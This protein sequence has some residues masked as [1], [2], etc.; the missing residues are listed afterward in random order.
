MRYTWLLFDADG[1]LFDYDRAEATALLRTF[2]ELGCSYEARYAEVYRQI[3]GEI[4][5]EF[6]QG[7]ISQ[8]RLRTR[9]FEL[10]FEDIGVHCDAKVFSTRYL[11][12]LAEGTDLIEGAE[13]V[14]RRLHGK[15][16]LVLITNGIADVQRPRF[17]SSGLRDYFADI[18]I[19]EEVGASKPDPRIFDSAFQAMGWPKKEEVLIVGDS[20]TSDVKGGNNYGI[21]ACWFNPR[22]DP[23]A[24]DVKIRFEIRELRELLTLFEEI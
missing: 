19:S 8:H 22:Q 12:H 16:G 6:E 1:T 7:K 23:C 17:A 15:A 21:D 13:E 5:R 18:V 14:V 11:L 24:V 9:R 3:N 10:L 4:W 2:R 20:L